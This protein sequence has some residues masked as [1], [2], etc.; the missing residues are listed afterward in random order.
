MATSHDYRSLKSWMKLARELEAAKFD[1]I[2]WA[3]HSGVYNT[4]AGSRDAAVQRAVRF[5][6]ND[7]ASSS[8]ALSRHGASQD[9][10]SVRAVQEHPFSFARRAAWTTS[11][12]ACR[13]EHRHFLSA[14][15]MAK[16]RIRGVASHAER[17]R[18]PRNMSMCS[19][20]CW[21]AAG[22]RPCRNARPRNRRLRRSERRSF[23]RS[24]R[25]VL[26]LC[27]ASAC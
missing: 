27:G 18:R 17:Y 19:T 10:P 1:A 21:R 25:R 16:L 14:L 22:R 13:M 8:R 12:R 4:Y 6:I 9:S 7:R 5:P 20:S 26:S 11:L 24:R 2:F 23:R 15:G 3:D